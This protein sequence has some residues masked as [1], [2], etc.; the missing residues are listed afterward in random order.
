M[1]NVIELSGSEAPW[2]AGGAWLAEQRVK[3]EL[4]RLELAEQAS[5]PSLR[6]LEEVEEGL[7]PIPSSMY[8]PM[9][10]HLGVETKSFAAECLRFY[11]F[12]AFDALFG[13]EDA[14]LKEAA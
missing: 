3:A 5:A 12:A 7:R 11:D 10:A 2:A 6:W 14:A 8:A 1:I 4:T 13:G 9:A